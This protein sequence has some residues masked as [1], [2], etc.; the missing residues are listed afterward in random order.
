VYDTTFLTPSIEYVASL[1]VSLVR[2]SFNDTIAQEEW[3]DPATVMLAQRKLK[4]ALVHTLMHP[5][6]THA[7]AACP[8]IACLAPPTFH[9]KQQIN[10]GGPNP[11]ESFTAAAKE[12]FTVVSNFVSNMLNAQSNLIHLRIK[13]LNAPVE[14]GSWAGCVCPHPSCPQ[15]SH[16]PR[17]CSFSS[18]D[19][20]AFYKRDTNVIFIP[21]AIL[22]PPFF[23]AHRYHHPLSPPPPPCATFNSCALPPIPPSL[24][25]SLSP[26][27]HRPM[28]RNLG[29]LGSIIGHEFTHGFDDQGRL[30]DE[31]CMHKNWWPAHVQRSF[32]DRAKCVADV[33]RFVGSV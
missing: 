16:S 29:A 18:T 8:P 23:S 4:A 11:K 31:H 33:Y 14:R 6:R 21:S 20:D 5:P 12:D 17:I 10:L 26:C 9:T 13:R 27:L 1:M 3:L 22:Q 19:V 25:P 30:F 32:V 15:S 24:S 28:S 7:H 2:Q